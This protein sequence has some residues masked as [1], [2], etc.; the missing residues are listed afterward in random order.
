MDN[1]F[2][3]LIHDLRDHQNVLRYAAYL[4]RNSANDAA[5]IRQI[6]ESLEKE[7]EGVGGLAD[8]LHAMEK[9]PAEETTP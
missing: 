8:R 6:A 3:D 5:A 7:V 4:L 1:A 2:H 9:P